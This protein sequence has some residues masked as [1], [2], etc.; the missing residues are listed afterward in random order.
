MFDFLTG[1]ELSTQQRKIMDLQEFLTIAELQQYYDQ[2]QTELKVLNVSQI[3][4]VED[5]DLVSIGMTKPEMR[6]LRDMYK[7]QHSHG[8]L[9]IFKKVC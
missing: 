7:K 3:K 6:R 2:F 1:D 9:G 4:Y 5:S 8:A